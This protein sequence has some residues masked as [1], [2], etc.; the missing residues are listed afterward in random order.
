MS[1][2][3]IGASELGVV[4]RQARLA[5]GKLLPDLKRGLSSLGKPAKKHVVA[6]I[7]A[8]MPKSGGYAG[9]L[10][11]ATR[12]R[13][14]SD[15]GLTTAGVTIKT[16]ADGQ[17]RRRDVPSLNRGRLRKKVFGNVNR[18]VTQSVPAGFWDDAMDKT[19]VDAQARAREVLDKT[20]ER[21]KGA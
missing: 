10:V 4:A 19:S 13:V 17:S 9:L 1:F 11:K 7:E 14:A 3:V 12:V 15:T 2:E 20:I 5:G 18:W 21:L 6:A 8:K 16:Y